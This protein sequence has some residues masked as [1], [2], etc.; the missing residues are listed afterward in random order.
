MKRPSPLRIGACVS[1]LLVLSPLVACEQTVE[2]LKTTY[3]TASDLFSPADVGATTGAWAKCTHEAGDMGIP[4]HC[5][6]PA[7]EGCDGF[8][9]M[10][11]TLGDGSEACAVATS[12]AY[13]CKTDADC[14]APQSGTAK[15][16]C[17]GECALPCRTT[18]ECPDGMICYDDGGITNGVAAHCQ[19][20]I[21]CPA[22]LQ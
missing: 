22:S 15:A 14:P 1:A 12:C 21:R 3:E 8:S 13:P 11:I 7:S 20:T 16:V 18:A 4:Q 17:A 2:P 9:S 6:D 5:P 10:R 19:W